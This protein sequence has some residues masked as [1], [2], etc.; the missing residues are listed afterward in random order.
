MIRPD[1]VHDRRRLLRYGLGM[2]LGACL[3]GCGKDQPTTTTQPQPAGEGRTPN[4]ESI[5]AGK[6]TARPG[7]TTPTAQFRTGLQSLGITRREEDVVLY[8]PASYTHETPVPLVVMFHGAGGNAHGILSLLRSP[9]DAHGMIA[10]AIDSVGVSWDIVNAGGFGVDIERLDLALQTVFSR[11]A[12]DPAR[13]AFAGFSDGASY[14]LSVGA[15][16]GDLAGALIAFS[17]GFFAPGTAEGRPRIFIAHGTLD[18]TLPIDQTSRT[19]VPQL[20]DAG[21][22][23]EYVEFN[24]VHSMPSEI[25]DRGMSWWLGG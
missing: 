13:I 1:G 2:I 12:I 22:D 18:V 20:T 17:P 24:G 11:F 14:A 16:N 3:A 9:A 8:V 7:T 25:V 10:L 23:V 4:P 15:T 6:V 21:Y 19:I 5:A